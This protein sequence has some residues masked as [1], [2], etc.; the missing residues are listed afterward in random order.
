MYIE[1]RN[2]AKFALRIQKMEIRPNDSDDYYYWIVCVGVGISVN[3]EIGA[4][5]MNAYFFQPI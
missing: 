1:H 5:P 2:N 3:L 4:H